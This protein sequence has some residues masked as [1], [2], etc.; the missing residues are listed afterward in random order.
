MKNLKQPIERIAK[1]Y[2]QQ[3]KKIGKLP[4]FWSIWLAVIMVSGPH[5]LLPLVIITL[6]LSIAGTA[7]IDVLQQ[8][9][10]AK[11]LVSGNKEQNDGVSLGDQ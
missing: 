4:I 10:A 1:Q 5:A 7:L 11:Q 2:Y 3:L 9:R 6:V 8:Q